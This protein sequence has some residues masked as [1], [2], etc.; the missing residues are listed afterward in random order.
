MQLLK[1]AII[2]YTGFIGSH[3]QDHLDGSFDRYNSKNIHEIH[4]KSYDI[5]YL[6]GLPATKW[7]INK[8]P[9]TDIKNM[10]SLQFHLL[11]ANIS[12]VIL[13]S[14]I[15]VYDSK[16]QLQDEQITKVSEDSYGKHRYIMEEWIRINYSTND[17]KYHIIRLPALFGVGLKKNIIYDLIHN[18]GIAN[19]NP[20]TFYQWYNVA[21]LMSD[22][23]YVITHD[24][25][26][27]NLFSEPILTL[28]LVKECFPEHNISNNNCPS[29]TV[30]NY[31]TRYSP[32]MNGYA[33]NNKE[34]I[35]NCVKNYLK[36]QKSIMNSGRLLVSNLAWSHIWEDN[37]LDILKKYGMSNVE[38]AITKYIDWADLNTKKL[39]ELKEK[40]NKYSIKIYSL[41]AIFF[42]IDSNIFIDTHG[43]IS[44][45]KYV[46]KT[47][48]YLGV[49]KIVFGSPKNR[50]KPL[51]MTLDEADTIFI[52]A[53]SEISDTAAE[54]NI[55]VCLEPNAI[56][57]EC[58]YIT[59]INEA[60]SI[61]KEVNNPNFKLNLDLGNAKM[62]KDS[63]DESIV[64]Y[65][66][67]IQISE[68]YL[69]E[70]K[71]SIQD[72]Y[73]K[74]FIKIFSRE[75]LEKND[76]YISLEMKMLSNYTDFLPNIKKFVSMY[77]FE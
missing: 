6:A 33:Y 23:K 7:M 24:I 57:Y 4:G 18:N 22:M 39:E 28:E 25:D 69:A 61:I 34:I 47:A 52:E 2:G 12:R 54:Y 74:D 32:S 76:L 38:L 46:L 60:I 66:G 44:H 19:I 11:Q 16:K 77:G 15:D 40:F 45:F 14:T 59:T 42:G 70:I 53:I 8:D 56:D 37:A 58:N 10:Q 50:F 62:M 13:I 1:N 26:T 75:I 67:H 29:T 20:Y 41:Q 71:N 64:E 35:F 9:E 49:Q 5:V 31:K 72:S 68:P 36:V 21:D 48:S 63:F 3:I 73:Y 51:D 17:K 55:T 27:L 65:V 30:Y 43:F